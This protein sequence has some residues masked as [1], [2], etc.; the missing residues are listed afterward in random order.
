MQ[1]AAEKRGINLTSR[2]RPLT[3]AD[4]ERFDHIIGTVIHF[5]PS[6]LTCLRPTQFS[7]LGRHRSCNAHAPHRKN[8]SGAWQAWTKRT[9]LPSGP[10]QSTGDHSTQTFPVTTARRQAAQDLDR[11]S[12]A[13]RSHACIVFPRTQVKLMTQ[14]L[15]SPKFAE[16]TKVPD[17]YFG[18]SKGFE[19]VR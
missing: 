16:F 2:S 9:S 4:L 8:S 13:N 10:P 7:T 14:Y 19:L 12:H 1:Q 3:P 11:A 5:S 17:P 15:R 18:G 6:G